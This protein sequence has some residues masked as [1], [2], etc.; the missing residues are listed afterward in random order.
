[1]NR[2]VAVLLVLLG[3]ASAFA[4]SL[5]T[6]LSGLA[7]EYAGRRIALLQ[8]TE[9]LT[10]QP[11]KIGTI[12]I[13]P[14]GSF[15]TA[16]KLSGTSHCFAA[17]D[18]W[19]A[20]IYLEPGK[21]YQVVLPP[22]QPLS[23]S[24]KQNPFFQPQLVSL[25]IQN[26]D[27]TDI[28]HLIRV[29]E[30]SYS[31]LESQYFNQLFKDKS[32]PAADS[33]IAKLSRSFPHNDNPYFEQYK[34]YRYASIRFAVNQ[35]KSNEFI[36]SYLDHPPLNFNLPPFRQLFNQQF[37]NY[38]NTES[39]QLNGTNFRVLV[40]TAN[41]AG[42]EQY[43]TQN[44]GW[45]HE[46][47]R[48]VIMKGINDAYYQHTYSPA[49]MLNLLDKIQQSN[50]PATDKKLALRL[51]EKLR[52]LSP[53]TMAPN[54]SIT[55]FEGEEQELSNFNGHLTYLHFTSV[56]NPICRQ[57]LD[58]LAKIE[59]QFKGQLT[60]VNLLPEANLDKKELILQQHWAGTFFT[61]NEEARESYRVKTFPSSY[62]IDETG[63]LWASPALNPLDGLSHQLA[64]YFKQK[65]LERFRN[66]AK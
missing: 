49:T 59:Q 33:L 8:Q 27:D 39:N 31:A 44:K 7:P 61:V 12:T 42:I 56:T 47:S 2:F 53:G 17:F 41:L 26:S 66:Q 20:E 51:S 11:Q 16:V 50:W 64:G 60:I 58:E 21:N 63:K 24:E 14:D 22:F 13:L 28:N 25:G 15:S 62:L 40:G 3:C 19:Q 9:P 38:F 57:Q 34:F 54:I 46:L 65:Q 5:P 45:S 6:V 18:R 37:S 29:F 52:Y 43:L 48:M 32:Q 35:A 55:N 10:N 30:Q 1:M 4:Q 36:K 23:E